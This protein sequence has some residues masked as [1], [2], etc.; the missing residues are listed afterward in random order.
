MNLNIFKVILLG[1]FLKSIK[2]RFDLV[3]PIKKFLF[4]VAKAHI[5]KRVYTPFFIKLD[6]FQYFNSI[7]LAILNLICTI[8]TRNH[9][10]WLRPYILKIE[11]F[12]SSL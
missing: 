9:F 5:Q 3:F 1:I 4:Y 12:F 6:R 7:C 8:Y 11:Y 2:T 10:L